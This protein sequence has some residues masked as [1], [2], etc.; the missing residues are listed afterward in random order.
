ME[1]YFTARATEE[2][3]QTCGQS[4]RKNMKTVTDESDVKDKYVVRHVSFPDLG[5]I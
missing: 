2:I 4:N 3:T 1:K 5:E